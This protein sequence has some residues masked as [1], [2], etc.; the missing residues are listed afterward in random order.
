MLLER[1]YC[2]LACEDAGGVLGTHDWIVLFG[3][4]DNEGYVYASH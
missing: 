4:F 2:R 1:T 3:D